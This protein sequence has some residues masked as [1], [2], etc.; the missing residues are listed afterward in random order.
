[1]KK[2]L[3]QS[4]AFTTIEVLVASAI[5]AVILVIALVMSSGVARLTT[6]TAA[7]IST[8]QESRTAFDMMTRTLNQALLQ[9]YWDYDNPGVPKRY[10]R[11]SEL[12]L[13]AGRGADLTGWADAAGS[14][15]FFQAPMGY[16]LKPNLKSVSDLLNGVGFY[17]RYSPS[18]DLPS[19]LQTTASSTETWRLW[20]YL[21][22]TEE[23][24]V[25]SIYNGLPQEKSDLS[26]FRDDIADKPEYSHILAN[27]VVLLLIRCEY[28]G[29]DGQWNAQYAYDSRPVLE[30]DKP[31]PVE[32]NQT[33]PIVHLTLV[34]IDE[35]TATKLSDYKQGRYDLLEDEPDLFR[36]AGNYKDDIAKFEAHLQ[37][38]PIGGI[39]IRY[40]IFESTVNVSSS[41]W[42]Q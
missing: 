32:M 34:V 8:F 42:S 12:H 20:M 29:A 1:V 25:Y 3:R 23:L 5:L 4:Q 27:H 40:R 31:P 38:G 15:I 24:K 33:P 39:P 37:K 30:A 2:H 19:Y 41:K 36:E 13:A 16:S 28:P 18:R 14:A 10:I 22:P 6:S 26:W 9:T 7:R 17:V 11:A 21:Q 35:A